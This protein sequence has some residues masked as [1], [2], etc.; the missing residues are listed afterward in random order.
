MKERKEMTPNYMAGLFDGEGSVEFTKRF[1]SYKGYTCRRIVCEMSMTDHYVMNQWFKTVKCGSLNSKKVP[2]GCK[3]QWRW[4][5]CF[6]DALRFA[7]M[8]IKTNE[9]YVKKNKLLKIIKH[10]EME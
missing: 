6:K 4:R 7:K 9:C 3:P 5:C 10:Y 2:T 8:I 1:D